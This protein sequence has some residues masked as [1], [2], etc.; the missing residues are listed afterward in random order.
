MIAKR[1]KALLLVPPLRAMGVI[2]EIRLISQFSIC[3]WLVLIEGI[4][5][6]LEETWCQR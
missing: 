2:M 4:T 1:V 3:R 5:G 6:V